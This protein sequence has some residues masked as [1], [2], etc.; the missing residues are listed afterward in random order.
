M[1]ANLSSSMTIPKTFAITVVG[2]SGAGKTTLVKSL[3]PVRY[4]ECGEQAESLIGVQDIN[5]TPRGYNWEKISFG[6][7][8]ITFMD[9]SVEAQFE[10]GMCGN[11]LYEKAHAFIFVLDAS[12]PERFREAGDVLSLLTE[13]IRV[14]NGDDNTYPIRVLANKV[15][16]LDQ[17]LNVDEISRALD[18]A[19]HSG[20]GRAIT[21]K[22]SCPVSGSPAGGE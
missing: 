15:D 13:E 11:G 18:I 1:G 16:K 9:L 3:R 19:G 20:L 17:A 7:H 21:L 5:P 14:T 2:L 4:T 10:V 22:L 6:N 8:T 12:V